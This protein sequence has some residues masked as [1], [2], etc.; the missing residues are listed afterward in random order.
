MPVSPCDGSA[1]GNHGWDNFIDDSS[2]NIG[3]IVIGDELLIGQVVDTNSGDIARMIAPAGWQ[4][5]EVRTVHDD[6]CAMRHAIEE[7]MACHDVVLTTGGLGPTKDDITKAT[8][9]DI[10]G[11]EM[12]MD[13][14]VLA[15][16]EEVFRKRGL[17]MNDLTRSQAIVPDSCKVIHNALGTAPVM[18][19]ERDGKVL[20]AMPGVPFETRHAFANEVLPRLLDRFSDRSV[21]GHRTL[22]IV[23]IT[24]SDLAER[25]SEWENGLQTG[26]HLAYLPQAG[27]IRLRIDCAGTNEEE[28]HLTLDEAV[29]WLKDTL[30]EHV[31]ADEDLTPEQ[32]LMQE[33]KART[34]TFGC[35]ESCTGGN[36]AHRMTMLPGVSEMFM[37]SVTAY[38]NDVKMHLLG[39][40]AKVLADNGA[41]SEPVAFQMAEGACRA[42]GVGCAVAT[43]GIAGPGGGSAE[44][45]VGM[46]CMGFVTPQRSVSRT[47]RFP[48][49]RGRVIDRATTVALLEMVKMLRKL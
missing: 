28:V 44:K 33:L 24:E 4:V 18:W 2:M 12:R 10:F 1:A 14:G 25:L 43:S 41:V 29:Q 45:P 19:F 32:L 49:D 26:L 6:A 16:V 22:V 13:Y 46:V 15:H 27:Y 21:L 34:L 47:F 31:L 5:G 17:R 8:L 23:D 7:M 30:G 37:G 39:V 11:G 40:D 9:R 3:I 38:S 20:V 42:L 36:I 35:A 48:G